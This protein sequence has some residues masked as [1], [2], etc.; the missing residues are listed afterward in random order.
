MA[1]AGTCAEVWACDEPGGVRGGGGHAMDVAGRRLAGPGLDWLGAGNRQART[2]AARFEC[3]G[4]KCG[5]LWW[6][7]KCLRRALHLVPW[8]P[9]LAWPRP[10][11]QLAAADVAPPYV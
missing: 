3:S 10:Y 1:I 7:D 11:Q 8:R 9:G 2:Q 5:V 6:P 4:R